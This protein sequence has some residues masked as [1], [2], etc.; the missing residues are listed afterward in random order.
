MVFWDDILEFGFG[1]FWGCGVE[2][3]EAVADSVDVDVNCYGG[4]VED[5]GEDAV[6]GFTSDAG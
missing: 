4:L 5:V 1:L 3:A 6:S 2:P